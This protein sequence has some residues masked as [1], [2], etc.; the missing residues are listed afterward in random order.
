MELRQLEY[1]LAIT[2]SAAFSRAALKLAVGQ[3]VLSRQIKALEDEFG[4]KLY[5]RTGRG[6]ALTEAGKMVETYARTI[7]ETTAQAHKDIASLGLSPTGSVRIG[8]PPSVVAILAAP[9][10][11]RFSQAYPKVLMGVMEGFSAHVLDWLLAG[12]I[13]VAVLYDTPQ[14]KSLMADEL[15]T[16]ELFLLGPM[17]DPHGI[18]GDTVATSA[19]SEIPLIL[20][21]RPHGL[22]LLV[23]GYL[24]RLGGSAPNVV[25]EVDAM[26]STL[27]MVEA[28]IGYTVLSYPCVHD[29]VEA[30]R[31]R[32][33]HLTEPTIARKLVLASSTVRPITGASRALAGMVRAH[34]QTMVKTGRWTPR[35]HARRAEER[36]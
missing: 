28:G 34:A 4:A 23:D 25:I 24:A 1:F 20:P 27:Q 19:L 33:W 21:S 13:D 32:Y 22:R 18:G 11:Q 10:V 8:M 16:D 2:D 12:Q 15:W 30:K 29:L 31:L 36:I 3:P 14:S 7:L 6:V 35:P 9:I 17:E 5:H 26:H